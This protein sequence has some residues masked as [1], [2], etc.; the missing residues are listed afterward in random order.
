MRLEA[1]DTDAVIDQMQAAKARVLAGET[2][3]RTQG[4]TKEAAWAL[5]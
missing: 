5:F 3:Y 2:K 1:V 4:E